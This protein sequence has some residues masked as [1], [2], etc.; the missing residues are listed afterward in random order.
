MDTSKA[1]SSHLAA[2]RSFH[3]GA[4]GPPHPATG[5]GRCGGAPAASAETPRANLGAG[6][7][8]GWGGG[9]GGW[10]S[11]MPAVVFIELV[12]FALD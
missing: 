7:V 3:C 4:V 5:S 6:E 8:G 9:Q 1:N 11:N 12:L 2:S 10:R